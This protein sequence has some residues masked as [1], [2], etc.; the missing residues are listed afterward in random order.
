MLDYQTARAGP[1]GSACWHGVH[2]II[3][4]HSPTFQRPSI[5]KADW[6]W[7]DGGFHGSS[8][9][10]WTCPFPW[11]LLFS[12]CHNVLLSFGPTRW[13]LTDSLL[14][15]CQLDNLRALGANPLT[16][17]SFCVFSKQVVGGLP[18]LKPTLA[19]NGWLPCSPAFPALMPAFRFSPHVPM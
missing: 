13:L 6:V 7:L 17:W 15:R 3:G 18:H 14:S 1:S 10:L 11:G 9:G 5:K 2:R 16:L 4:V 19:W 12:P 8:W